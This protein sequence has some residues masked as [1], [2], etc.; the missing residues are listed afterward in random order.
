MDTQHIADHEIVSRVKYEININIRYIFIIF[1]F[2]EIISLS[3]S[4]LIVDL[5]RTDVGAKKSCDQADDEGDGV[6]DGPVEE[7]RAAVLLPVSRRVDD[8][9]EHDGEAGHHHGPHQGDQE[10]QPGQGGGQEDSEGVQDCPG[11]TKYY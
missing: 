4:K 10:V 2:K 8:G 9:G 6:P 5:Q 1:Y 7:H 11:E 3:S